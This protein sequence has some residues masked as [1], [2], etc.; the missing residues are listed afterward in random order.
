[1]AKIIVGHAGADRRQARVIFELGREKRLVILGSVEAFCRPRQRDRVPQSRFHRHRRVFHRRDRFS[2]H[3]TE[4]PHSHVARG[5]RGRRAN[6]LGRK[7]G[8]RR[9]CRR[10][11]PGI[12]DA[13]RFPES[14]APH[15]QLRDRRPEPDVAGVHGAHVELGAGRRERIALQTGPEDHLRRAIRG[16]R[17]GRIRRA[18]HLRSVRVRRRAAA[19]LASLARRRR[20]VRDQWRPAPE[21]AERVPDPRQGLDRRLRRRRQRWHK[22]SFGATKCPKPCSG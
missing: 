18:R 7:H 12:S 14:R 16:R 6:R 9:L 15:D 8:A 2:R 1:M 11:A 4:L 19:R 5:G 3:A 22:P 10:V 13:P 20:A 17:V 21:R